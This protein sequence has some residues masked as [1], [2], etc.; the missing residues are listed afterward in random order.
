[1]GKFKDCFDCLDVFGNIRD[2]REKGE[3]IGEAR[4]ESLID[5]IEEM[6]D[7]DSRRNLRGLSDDG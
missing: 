3:K 1:M 5:R 6:A 4:R 2:I 7:R